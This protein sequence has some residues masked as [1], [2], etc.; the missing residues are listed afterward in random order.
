MKGSFLKNIDNIILIY[1]NNYNFAIAVTN[2]HDILINRMPIHRS[3]RWQ[4]NN[5]AH[6]P[7]NLASVRTIHDNLA[8]ATVLVL[9]LLVLLLEWAG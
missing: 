6:L 4:I 2:H 8:I 3:N 9:L 5:F 7:S 1:V